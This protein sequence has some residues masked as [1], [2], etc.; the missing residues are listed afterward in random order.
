MRAAGRDARLMRE[1]ADRRRLSAAGCARL[2]SEARQLLAGWV[3]DGWAH[4][5][6]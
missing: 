2:G 1:L 4:L 6:I 5:D 3:D